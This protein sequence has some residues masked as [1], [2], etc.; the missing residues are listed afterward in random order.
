[1]PPD[2]RKASDLGGIVHARGEVDTPATG[3]RPVQFHLAAAAPLFG[4]GM[5]QFIDIR[6]A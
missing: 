6:N 4:L 5:R 2:L 1:M 3:P